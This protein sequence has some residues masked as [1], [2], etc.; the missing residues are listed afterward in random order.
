MEQKYVDPL[1]KEAFS[2]DCDTHDEETR[3]NDTSNI[4]I[5]DIIKE[6]IDL[7]YGNLRRF[8]KV[9]DLPYS[10]VHNMLNRGSVSNSS[11]QVVDKMCELLN[12]DISQLAK[13]SVVSAPAER[14]AAAPEQSRDKESGKRDEITN[15]IMNI[16]ERLSPEQ[17]K[18]LLA[19]LHGLAGLK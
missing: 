9:A 8:C 6:R 7:K 18:M 14:R 10:T 12:I 13:G 4:P 5:E 15:E 2:S 17:K 19:Q 3:L 11:V 16:I 1:K